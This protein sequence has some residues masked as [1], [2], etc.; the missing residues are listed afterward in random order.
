MTEIKVGDKVKRINIDATGSDVV[1]VVLDVDTRYAKVQFDSVGKAIYIVSLSYLSKVEN[2]EFNSEFKAQ[3]LDMYVA[4]S[5]EL[6]ILWKENLCCYN[7]ENQKLQ[8][9]QESLQNNIEKFKELLK[10]A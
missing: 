1:D 2:T 5:T 9:I 3:L 4:Q 6:Y 8:N 10:N 7:K